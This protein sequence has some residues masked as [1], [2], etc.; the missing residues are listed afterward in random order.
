MR[1]HIIVFRL[2][3]V[4]D[5]ID[6]LCVDPLAAIGSCPFGHLSLFLPD[7]RLDGSCC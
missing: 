6:V 5:Q 7:S 2:L 1:Q 4:T 3:V